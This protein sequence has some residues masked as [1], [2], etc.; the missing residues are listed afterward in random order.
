M[1]LCSPVT[2]EAHVQRLLDAFEAW[3]AALGLA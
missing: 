2:T 3:L 1:L